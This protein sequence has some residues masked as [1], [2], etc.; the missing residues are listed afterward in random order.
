MFPGCVQAM[1]LYVV[2]AA[3]LLVAG[4]IL[5]ASP[6]GALFASPQDHRFAFL[7]LA[8]ALLAVSNGAARSA[9][10]NSVG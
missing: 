1:L 8:F 3:V 2:G 6:R 7:D 10:S 9:H 4:G 5:F